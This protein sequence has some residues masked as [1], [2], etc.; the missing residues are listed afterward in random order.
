MKFT[1]I[2]PEQY[3]CGAGSCPSVHISE[4]G[5]T[6]RITGDLIQT[7]A[8]TAAACQTS[9]NAWEATIE[10]SA[11]MVLGDLRARV[12][13]LEG[14]IRP[15]VRWLELMEKYV[16]EAVIDEPDEMTVSRGSHDVT[17]GDLRAAKAALGGTVT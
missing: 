13:A 8:K 3:R 7:Q 14:A 4:D 1:D 15:F 2:T 6:L 16:P 11:D 17:F 10:V 5:K 12:S 9:D